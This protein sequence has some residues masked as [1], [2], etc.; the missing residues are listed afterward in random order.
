MPDNVI[1][2]RQFNQ[3]PGSAKRKRAAARGPV[4]I[5]HRGEPSHVLLTIDEYRHLKGER[6]SIVELLGMDDGGD[7]EFDPPRLEL[8]LR[9]A[10]LS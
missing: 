6:P 7:I 2:S 3:D 10:D 8:E 1:S 9:P 5:T 4:L